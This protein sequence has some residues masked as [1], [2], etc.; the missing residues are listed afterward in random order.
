MPK[1][2]YDVS[3]EDHDRAASGANAP[4]PGWY[5]ARIKSCA[6]GFAKDDSGKS[7]KSRPRIELVYEIRDK[8]YRGAQVYDYIS[9]LEA[10]KWKL[11]QFL[12]AVGIKT[13]KKEKGTFDTDDV[14]GTDVKL[15]VRGDTYNDEYR[16]KVGRVA[17]ADAETD[18]D[19]EEEE[20]TDEEEEE[21]EEEESDEEEDEE[22]DEDEEEL[23]EEDLEDEEEEEE[24]EEEEDETPKK[25]KKVASKSKAKKS[26][27][28]KKGKK[29]KTTK[30]VK[31]KKGKSKK[32]DDL[33]F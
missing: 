25:S 12:Q 30:P 9:L 22:E 33:P 15:R 19:D 20:E 27:P 5:N 13:S 10:S 14:Q 31:G 2:K 3:G 26:P 8:K 23:E 32:D 7:D 17:S 11:D 21:E 29:A 4:K 6:S 1:I 28:A 16:A 24:E 18:E